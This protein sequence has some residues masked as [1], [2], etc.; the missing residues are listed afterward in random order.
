MLAVIP[1]DPPGRRKIDHREALCGNRHQ[2]LLDQQTLRERAPDLLRRMRHL[3]LDDERTR[4]RRSK[5]ARRVGSARAVKI[6]VE[7][8]GIKTYNL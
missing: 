7:V 4:G 8:M 1:T 6:S 2:P 5:I 3:A